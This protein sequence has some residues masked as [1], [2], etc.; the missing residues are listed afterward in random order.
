MGLAWTC[1][2][3]T[4][5]GRHEE[6]VALIT[7]YLLRV[8][9]HEVVLILPTLRKEKNRRNK[10]AIYVLWKASKKLGMAM[11]LSVDR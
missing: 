3:K 10:T 6:M 2:K 5:D 7:V 4:K 8:S 11:C 9:A 1:D